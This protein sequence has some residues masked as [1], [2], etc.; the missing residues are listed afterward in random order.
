MRHQK[1]KA[2]VLIRKFSSKTKSFLFSDNCKL[3]SMFQDQLTF[4]DGPYS[5]LGEEKLN[6]TYNWTDYDTQYTPPDNMT[7]VHKAFQY[8]SSSTLSSIPLPGFFTTYN[9]GGYVF[10][11]IGDVSSIQAQLRSLRASNWFDRRTRTLI[12]EFNLYNPNINCFAVCTFAIEVLPSGNFLPTL[13][14]DIVNLFSKSSAIRNGIYY[15]YL[16][17]VF[18]MVLRELKKMYRLRKAYLTQFW[19]WINW[20]IIA[21]SLA[22]FAIW[23]YRTNFGQK[24][25]E[26]FKNRDREYISFRYLNFWNLQMSALIAFPPALAML[27]FIKLLRFNRTISRLT[28]AIS[29]GI[30]E[31]SALFLIFA[32]LF[33]TF[34]QAFYLTLFDKV[35][36]FKNIV[37]STET[38]F[39]ILLGKFEMKTIME[40]NSILVV[41]LFI[42]FNCVILMV[43]LNLIITTISDTFSNM[44]SA[45]YLATTGMS[46]YVA[47]RLFDLKQDFKKGRLFKRRVFYEEE[48][49]PDNYIGHS[50]QLDINVQKLL[51]QMI[52]VIGAFLIG[53]FSLLIVFN[54]FFFVKKYSTMIVKRIRCRCFKI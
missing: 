8:R 38:S 52:R 24:L 33:M 23:T 4:C 26:S 31:L 13:T 25:S 54:D 34:V 44:D 49:R 41:P 22:A 12:V 50:E 6:F 11:M 53:L 43:L 16:A 42:A 17:L 36:A 10:D 19:S 1:T 37:S 51:H 35:S 46:E 5:M 40:A 28:Q 14:I 27:K 9:G 29:M 3:N 7:N 20:V 32:I 39:Q 21:T 30:K 48:H 45:K 15:A 47:E 2:Y 18:W